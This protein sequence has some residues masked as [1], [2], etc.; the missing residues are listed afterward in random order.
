MFLF[1]IPGGATRAFVAAVLFAGG[2]SLVHAAPQ[3]NTPKKAAATNAPVVIP[4]SVFIIPKNPRQGRDPFFP[5]STRLFAQ[6]A[7]KNT[8]ELAAAEVM[9]NGV[10]GGPGH[11]LAIIN[12]E[13]FGEGDEAQIK[14]PSGRV[15]VK[16]LE[17]GQDSALVEIAGQRRE[18]HLRPGL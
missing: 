10:S 13:T 18:L 12:G 16:C 9:L 6:A 1:Y 5:S 4:K 15:R 7:T 17:I 2:C 8:T 11:R 14:T 3:K